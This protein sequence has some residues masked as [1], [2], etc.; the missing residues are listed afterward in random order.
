MAAESFSGTVLHGQLLEAKA[1]KTG[2]HSTY[3]FKSDS[4]KA[5][6]HTVVDNQICTVERSSRKGP[7]PLRPGAHLPIGRDNAIHRAIVDLL[8][9]NDFGPTNGE[10]GVVG[11]GE[12]R[13]GEGLVGDS[14]DGS[15]KNVVEKDDDDESFV[16]PAEDDYLSC[17]DSD[18]ADDNELDV[19]P[20]IEVLG[21]QVLSR[22]SLDSSLSPRQD[23][24]L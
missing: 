12:H 22:L 6:D 19:L 20:E 10:K 24:S 13:R 9:A 11:T 17:L 15:E 7:H 8:W 21:S 4:I 23:R 5:N 14:Q 1:T 3:I 2:F 16:E 18:S